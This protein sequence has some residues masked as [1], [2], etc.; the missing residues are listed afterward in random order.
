MFRTRLPGA[1]LTLTIALAPAVWAQDNPETTGFVPTAKR[2]PLPEEWGQLP[3]ECE[4]PL[5]TRALGPFGYEQW[6]PRA[7]A[8]SAPPKD[9]REKAKEALECVLWQVRIAKLSTRDAGTDRAKRRVA[10]AEYQR[11]LR[12]ETSLKLLEDDAELYDL[13]VS[14]YAATVFSNLFRESPSDAFFSSPR[15]YFL[16]EVNQTATG[17]RSLDIIGNFAFKGTAAVTEGNI[18]STIQQANG[19]SGD[20][21]L[22]FWPNL[23]IG[24]T[25][26]GKIG[27]GFS[28]AVGFVSVPQANP[29]TGETPSDNFDSTIRAG[30]Q[31]KVLAGKWENSFSELSWYRD[32]RFEDH[33]HRFLARARLVLSRENWDGAGHGLGGFLEGSF[34]SDLTKGTDEARITVGLVLPIDKILEA[35]LNVGASKKDE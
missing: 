18:G 6:F 9:R 5:V 2:E 3:K 29:D 34:N 31:L 16:F 10:E 4:T 22:V 24:P 20:A 7:I 17:D 25:T 30:F 8:D 19:L 21:G 26:Y 15:P 1:V 35:I 28:A 14:A 23:I 11:L 32:P 27:V 33:P 12:I 13:K